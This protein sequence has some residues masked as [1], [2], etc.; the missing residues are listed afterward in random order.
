MLARHSSKVAR[1]VAARSFGPLVVFSAFLSGMA[2]THPTVPSQFVIDPAEPYVYIKFDHIGR[3]KPA[4][5]G[6]G[7]EGLWLRLVNNC[8]LPITVFTFD[9]GTGDPEL[10]SCILLCRCRVFEALRN[11]SLK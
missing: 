4:T 5:E 6:E 10:V 3:R 7:S 2:Q 11:S 1:S 8:N 9:L